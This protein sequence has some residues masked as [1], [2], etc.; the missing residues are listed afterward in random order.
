MTQ[1]LFLLIKVLFSRFLVAETEGENTIVLIFVIL[2]CDCSSLLPCTWIKSHC[3]DS[4]FC[5]F[6]Y[7]LICLFGLEWLQMTC[8]GKCSM[9]LVMMWGNFKFFICN[10]FW[11]WF[12]FRNIVYT[13]KFQ[14][15]AK[16]FSNLHNYSSNWKV[17]ADSDYW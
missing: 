5:G 10:S 9:K 8:P 15:G 2:K 11:F 6:F 1:S 4:F 3:L 14:Q 16:Y 17:S 7:W 13:C 12:T